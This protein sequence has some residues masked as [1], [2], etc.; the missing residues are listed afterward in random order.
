MDLVQGLNIGQAARASGVSAKMIRHYEMLGLLPKARRSTAGYRQY[1]MSDVH[2]LRFVRRARSLGFGIEAIRNLLDLWRNRR[3][4][5]G[6]VK[7]LAL[8]HAAEL[9]TRIEELQQMKRTLEQLAAE[10][11]GD[12]RPDCPILDDFASTAV[13]MTRGRSDTPERLRNSG[14]ATGPTRRSR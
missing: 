4:S 5:S 8:A 6:Q 12:E 1:A 7:R 13:P 10:C 3:R 9:A 11:L 2:M 14:L